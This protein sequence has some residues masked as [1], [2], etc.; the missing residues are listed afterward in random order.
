M[1]EA[2]TCLF[3]NPFRKRSL[4]PRPPRL[5]HLP[6][7]TLIKTAG[8]I[9]HMQQVSVICIPKEGH[10]EVRGSQ[11]GTQRLWGTS[12]NQARRAC[13]VPDPDVACFRCLRIDQRGELKGK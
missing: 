8:S 4:S 9:C 11:S 7:S 2:L 12:S 13:T 6:L 3:L 1:L 10:R 5:N